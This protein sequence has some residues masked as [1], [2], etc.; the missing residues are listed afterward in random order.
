MYKCVH[1]V[2]VDYGK[3]LELFLKSLNSPKANYEK[4]IQNLYDSL[5]NVII[6]DKTS[7]SF[8]LGHVQFDYTYRGVS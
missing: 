7:V 5:R 2:L 3:T 1:E 8:Y 6:S 4:E